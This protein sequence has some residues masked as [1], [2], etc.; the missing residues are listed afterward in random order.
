MVL[1]G[2]TLHRFDNRQ[3]LLA[4]F[5]RFRREAD[6]S[7]VMDGLDAANQQA[8]G[9]AHVAQPGRSAGLQPRAKIGA[10]NA[11]DTDAG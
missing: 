8:F 11:M 3:L 1:N 7:G 5:D 10:A 2:V 4:S 6:A 9:G